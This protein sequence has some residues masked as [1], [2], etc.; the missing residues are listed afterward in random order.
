MAGSDL[1]VFLPPLFSIDKKQPEEERERE[2]EREREEKERVMHQL[3]YSNL[4]SS[5]TFLFHCFFVSPN[6]TEL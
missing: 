6:Q 3:C 4:L 5:L 2:R 1:K